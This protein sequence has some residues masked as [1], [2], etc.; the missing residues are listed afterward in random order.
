M[1]RTHRSDLIPGEEVEVEEDDVAAAAAVVVDS[2]VR[3]RKNEEYQVEGGEC[4]WI[5]VETLA[6]AASVPQSRKRAPRMAAPVELDFVD[7]E[8]LLKPSWKFTTSVAAFALVV[9]FRA[10]SQ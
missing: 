4:S 3:Q 6:S 10:F 7:L 1:Y 8:S 9:P 5:P 2:Q